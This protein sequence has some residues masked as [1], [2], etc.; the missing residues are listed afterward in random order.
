MEM[1]WAS[2]EQRDMD[3]QERDQHRATKM[4]KELE[5]QVWHRMPRETVESPS[6]EILKAQLNNIPINLF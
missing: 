3:I 5:D 2:Q 6:L 1:V 4:T